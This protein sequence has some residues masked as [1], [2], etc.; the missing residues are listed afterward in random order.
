MIEFISIYMRWDSRYTYQK[1]NPEKKSD[2]KAYNSLRLSFP[3]SNIPIS[4]S[5]YIYF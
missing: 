3:P 4:L 1:Y 2:G 5:D